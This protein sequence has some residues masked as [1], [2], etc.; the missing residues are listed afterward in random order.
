MTRLIDVTVPDIGDYKDVPVIE[1]L[2]QPGDSVAADDP[3]VTLESDKATMDVPAPVAG[4]V[5]ELLAKVG[6]AYRKAARAED[7]GR[8]GAAAAADCCAGRSRLGGCRGRCRAGY[9]CP[10]CRGGPGGRKARCL[11]T[12]PDRR[13]RRCPAPRPAPAALPP[14]EGACEPVRC[15]ATHASWAS[16]RARNRERPQRADHARGHHAHVKSAMSSAA[17]RQD[18]GAR[19]VRRRARP[20]AVA[21]DRFREVWPDRIA[22]ASRI[23]KI[24]GANLTRNAV[25]SRT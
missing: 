4:I 2:V 1:L 22:A 10:R 20:A 18:A 23:K 11:G 19:R 25:V 14:R 15:A 5:R 24:S 16:T 7:R 13:D 17:C 21:E 3:I 8:G 9:C 12:G 6:D